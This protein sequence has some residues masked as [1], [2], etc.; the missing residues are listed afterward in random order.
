MFLLLRRYGNWN[1]WESR[2]AGNR[3]TASLA[4]VDAAH[5]ARRQRREVA[6]LFGTG[7]PVSIHHITDT[8]R[9]V[10]GAGSMKRY[11][12]RPAVCPFVGLSTGHSSK[13]CCCG[14][15][16]DRQIGIQTC[17]LRHCRNEVV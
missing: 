17:L 11:G 15:C 3:K 10:C 6:E 12:V 16:W 13:H 4:F 8:A 7:S 14:P 9:T 1:F 2:N 5:T